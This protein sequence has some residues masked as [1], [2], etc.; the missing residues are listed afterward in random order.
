MNPFQTPGYEHLELS[1]QLVVAEAIKR[2]I[3]VE[4]LDAEESFIRLQKNDRTEYIR[5]A[6]QTSAD[7][8]ITH[9]LLD[10]KKV[11]KQ[12]LDENGFSIPKGSSH[13]QAVEAI[14]Q[15]P[16][17]QGKAC[18]IKPKS[19]NFGIGIS[20]LEASHTQTQF[21]KAVEHAFKE[22]ASIL[23]EAFLT[24]KECRFLVIGKECI[25][26]LHRVPAHVVGDGT[27]SI[28]EL[29]VIKN[30]DPRRG[31]GYK[32]PLEYLE[33]GPTELSILEEQGLNTKSVLE[34][35]KPAW[36]R[37]NSNIST[38]GDS[39]DYSDLVHPSYKE[40]AAKATQTLG[41]QICGV[42]I[43][44]EDPKA[45]A[46]PHNHGILELNWNPVLYFHDFPYEG[47]NRHTAQH[48]LDLLSF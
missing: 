20:I 9:F 36:L 21:E 28:E 33:L 10:N 27:H 4:V 38:G 42:D 45:P 3:Q 1:T 37:H 22:D 6:T 31:K 14:K 44:L 15:A 2:N 13:T 41:A 8:Y 43:I 47:K 19:T 26:V 35:G 23:I 7:T 17:W 34:R 24:G 16:L 32:T 48:V 46:S 11:C 39:I 29:V 5:K 25:A 18:V 40:I 12:I 30:Q